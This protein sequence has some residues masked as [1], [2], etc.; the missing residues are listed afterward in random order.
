MKEN[1]EIEEQFCT[2][3]PF[4]KNGEFKPQKQDGLYKVGDEIFVSCDSYY[5]AVQGNTSLQCVDG[6]RWLGKFPV[7]VGTCSLLNFNRSN[8]SL[9]Y[10]QHLKYLDFAIRIKSNTFFKATCQP[11]ERMDNG[12][13]NLNEN[14]DTRELEAV[15][16]CNPGWQLVRGLEGKT[17]IQGNRGYQWIGDDP[18]CQ[19]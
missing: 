15:F 11:L 12:E 7:C 6:P 8:S 3:P 5:K 17:C 4:I 2:V 13:W 9:K 14:I 10:L 19:G 16:V 18:Q 1:K